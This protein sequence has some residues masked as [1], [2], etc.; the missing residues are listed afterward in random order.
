MNRFFSKLFIFFAAGI[1]LFVF[2][3]ASTVNI[4]EDL[5]PSELIQRAQEASDRNRYNVALQYYEALLERNRTNIDLVITAEYEIA[6]IHY[7]QKKYQQART[8][9]N[10]LL[11]Y[12]E[13]P[14]EQFLP[15]QFKR[16][17]LIVL[18]SITEKEQPRFFSSKKTG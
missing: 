9:L 17:A 15:Q 11:E 14:D 10:Y 1:T 6:F 2:A 18:N 7:K 12:Y 16:L 8:E 13:A 4:S 5:S 3:C